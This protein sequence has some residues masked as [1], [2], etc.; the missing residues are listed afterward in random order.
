MTLRTW[1]PVV[2]QDGMRERMETPADRKAWISR[3]L[4]VWAA[5]GHERSQVRKLGMGDAVPYQP[6]R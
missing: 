6:E 3:V 4:D 1:K 5:Q 2:M